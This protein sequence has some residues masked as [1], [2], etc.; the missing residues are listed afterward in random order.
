MA[1]LQ[2]RGDMQAA[3]A[4]LQ[5]LRQ[6]TLRSNQERRREDNRGDHGGR[7]GPMPGN[8][9]QMSV[10]TTT[11]APSPCPVQ[12]GINSYRPLNASSG[13]AGPE[14]EPMDIDKEPS[15][16]KRDLLNSSWAGSSTLHS[17]GA[18]PVI[19][20]ASAVPLGQFNIPAAQ[21]KRSTS[22]RRGLTN[23]HWAAVADTGEKYVQMSKEIIGI[24]MS[25]VY[26]D[27]DWQYTYSL[28][29]RARSYSQAADNAHAAGDFDAEAKLRQVAS[30]CSQVVDARLKLR[31]EKTEREAFQAASRAI[32]VARASHN[33][34]SAK[35]RAPQLTQGQTVTAHSISKH[36]NGQKTSTLPV[37][38][39]IGVAA[40]H[41]QTEENKA[42]QAS[43]AAVNGS[44]NLGPPP[45]QYASARR[46]TARER[47]LEHWRLNNAN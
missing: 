45:V 4:F 29:D 18:R 31:D 21:S 37:N 46:D 10:R 2:D 38:S 32:Q 14:G 19:D 9:R 8:P 26:Q 23:S 22:P 24:D 5:H 11:A 39:H 33:N 7:G 13:F 40:H 20:K 34:Y 25:S 28:E 3:R 47:F 27:N 41:L 35:I 43:Y 44:V 15:S 12:P 16:P 6:G 30:L 42:N 1:P 36:S 17:L